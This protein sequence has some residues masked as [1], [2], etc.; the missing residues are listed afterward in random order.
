MTHKLSSDSDI[1]F[2][3]SIVAVTGNL[4]DRIAKHTS[5]GGSYLFLFRLRLDG[6]SEWNIEVSE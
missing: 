6:A 2:L 1:Q 5:S 4:L 3:V